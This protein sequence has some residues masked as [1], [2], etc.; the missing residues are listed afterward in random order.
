MKITVVTGLATERNMNINA[1]QLSL[2]ITWVKKSIIV[3]P[4]AARHRLINF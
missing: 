3:I 4:S 1:S 2:L